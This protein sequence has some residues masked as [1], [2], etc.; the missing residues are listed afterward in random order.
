MSRPF[1]AQQPMQSSDNGRL[2]KRFTLPFRRFKLKSIYD[3]LN[4]GINKYPNGL[5]FPVCDRQ[6]VVK[7]DPEAARP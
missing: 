4:S 3:P 5:R 2:L 1:T 7:T 6:H